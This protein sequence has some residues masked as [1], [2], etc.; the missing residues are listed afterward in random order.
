MSKTIQSPVPVSLDYYCDN[1]NDGYIN[2]SPDGSCPGTGCEPEGC[3]TIPGNDCNDNNTTINPGANDSNCNGTDEDCD[4]T[5]DEHYIITATECGQGAC[6]SKGQKTCLNGNEIDSCTENSPTGDDSDCDGIDDNCDG[7]PDNSYTATETTCGKGVCMAT[8]QLECQAGIEI[9]T[10]TPGQPAEDTESICD[11]LDNDCDGQVDEGCMQ[12]QCSQNIALYKPVEDGGPVYGNMHGSL[13]VDGI[14][15]TS[16]N[17]WAGKGSP[18]S[19]IIDLQDSYIIE[20]I[21]ARPYG[22][23]SP[24]YYYD[25]EW[26]IKY[27]LDRINWYDFADVVKTKGSGTLLANGISIVNGNPGEGNHENY[28]E[29]EFTFTPANVRYIWFYVSKGDIGNDAN[30]EEMEIYIS[31]EEEPLPD[32]MPPAPPMELMLQ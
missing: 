5:A 20:K 2:S 32:S 29:Y 19:V 9:N 13:S 3:Q 31:C 8:G 23:Y 12:T 11:N 24:N 25:D 18:N 4:S 26:N 10:C 1:D 16:G 28:K 7:I 17:Y 22:W 30:L 27:S 21:I 14:K 6:Y 15:N